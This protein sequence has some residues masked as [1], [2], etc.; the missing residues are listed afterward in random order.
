M[1][2]IVNGYPI[3]KT[4]I[5]TWS[6]YEK[7]FTTKEAAI[8]WAKS[9]PEPDFILPETN[10][11]VKEKLEK[12][13]FKEN[14]YLYMYKNER[15][16]G[17]YL[18]VS[19]KILEIEELTL[20]TIMPGFPKN[21]LETKFLITG[22]YKIIHREKTIQEKKAKIESEH[23][24]Y[25]DIPFREGIATIEL[26]WTET[27]VPITIMSL[28]KVPEKYIVEEREIFSEGI[29][30]EINRIFV[31]SWNNDIFWVA[32]MEEGT[33]VIILSEGDFYFGY[34]EGTEKL[35]EYYLVE[36]IEQHF[37]LRKT[38]AID[39]EILGEASEIEEIVEFLSF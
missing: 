14:V 3:E 36:A 38:R 29:A 22:R 31:D 35:P 2:I 5:D 16:Y 23:I 37:D 32:E 21:A 25:R 26:P 39:P 20:N 12:Y 13:G 24:T 6:I 10:P 8:S 18:P 30:K 1:R 27:N 17:K 7:D 15:Q 34:Y 33:A 28:N 11:E 9:Q 19:P 4:L